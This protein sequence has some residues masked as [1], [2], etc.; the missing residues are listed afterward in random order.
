[1]KVYILD[2]VLVYLAL[3]RN[4]RGTLKSDVV[5]KDPVVTNASITTESKLNVGHAASIDYYTVCKVPSAAAKVRI[6][7]P[8]RRSLPSTSIIVLQEEGL[9]T[10]HAPLQSMETDLECRIGA[11]RKVVRRGHG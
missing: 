2:Y 11:Y 8:A 10:I 6:W 1:M 3:F 9:T 7:D 4:Y 5:N